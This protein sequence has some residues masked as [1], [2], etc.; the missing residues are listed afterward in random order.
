MEK[1]GQRCGRLVLLPCPFQGHINPMLQLGTILH[2]RGF[3]ITIVHTQFNS[4]NPSNHPN[5]KFNPIPDG[6]SAEDISSGDIVSLIQKLNVNCKS[7]LREYLSQLMIGRQGSHDDIVCI[8]YDELMYFTEAVAKFL[9]LPTIILHFVSQDLVPNLHPL[10]FKDLPFPLNR[11]LEK[12][13]QV[14]NDIYKM[15]TSSSAVIW[16]TMDC[17]ERSSLA[18]I[19]QQCQVPNLPIGPMHKLGPASP[20]SSLL[21]EDTN[22]MAWLGKQT[23]NSVIYVS[24]GSIASMNEKEL[25]EMAWGLA[26]SQKPFLWVVRPDS[27][28]NGKR[29]KVGLEL[30]NELVR[31]EIEKAITILMADKEGEAMRERAK[32]LKE[33]IELC[34][35]EGGSCNNSLNKLVE[36]IMSF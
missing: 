31:C 19:Q 30:E 2:C 18:C 29:N 17:L 26:N 16:N 15:R 10:R 4:P 13:S 28:T 23:K 5:F 21:K 9:K 6:L 27:S 22:C 20:S 11:N 1:N 7:H 32:N 8:I 24:L 36:I 33:K 34:I 25:A 14:I 12:F 3:S 35:K